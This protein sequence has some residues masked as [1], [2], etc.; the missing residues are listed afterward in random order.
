MNTVFKM[1]KTTLIAIGIVWVSALIILIISLTDLYPN[2]IFS[3]YRL[4]TGIA[5]LII[6]QFLKSIYNTAKIKHNA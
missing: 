3:K 1:K 2:T 4:M 5:F 6:S